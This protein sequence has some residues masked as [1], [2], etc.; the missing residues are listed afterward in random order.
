MISVTMSEE[1]YR[2]LIRCAAQMRSE[3]RARATAGVC[4]CELCAEIMKLN[5]SKIQKNTGLLS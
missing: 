4:K 3:H 2:L 1:S 5:E